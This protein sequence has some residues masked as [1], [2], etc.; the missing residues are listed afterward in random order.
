MSGLDRPWM[1]FSLHNRF[2][3]LLILPFVAPSYVFDAAHHIPP[4]L[5]PIDA[6]IKLLVHKSTDSDVFP[7]YKVQT[8]ADF[9]AHVLIVRRSDYTLDGLGENKIGEL[10]AGEKCTS[11]G[12]TIR[13]KDEYFLWRRYEISYTGRR[14]I[15]LVRLTVDIGLEGHCGGSY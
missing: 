3:C 13:G 1:I 5:G 8:V 14:K 9:S 12:S 2:H 15:L 11:Q 10:I 6:R 4:N 7:P